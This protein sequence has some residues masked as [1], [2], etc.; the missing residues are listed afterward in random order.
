MI[1]SHSEKIALG[2]VELA[3]QMAPNVRLVAA[4]GTDDGRIGTSFDRVSGGIAEADA[5]DGVVVLCDLGSAVLTA[6]T[7]L[8]FLDDEVRKRVLLADAPLVE[9][10]I[11]AAV[12]AEG[13]GS[14]EDV[15]R[16]AEAAA[17]SFGQAEEPAPGAAVEERSA[18]ISATA[19]LVNR[20]GLHAR[21]AADLVRLAT[22]FDAR[23]AVN[24]VDARSLLGIMGLALRAGNRVD[25][26][27]EGP[28]AREAA[29]ALVELIESGF[30]EAS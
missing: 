22:R 12:T 7:A 25:I 18:G 8:D 26:E 27:A 10:A 1:V 24:G 9:G 16:S 30:G 3:E 17:G 23:L 28:Q 14:V 20:D 21:P 19:V 2:V 29:D 6:E 4:G 5:G 15:L 13:G 11:A